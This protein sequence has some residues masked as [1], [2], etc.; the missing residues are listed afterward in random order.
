MRTEYRQ[1]FVL[2]SVAE[3]QCKPHQLNAKEN[4]GFRFEKT[5]WV[6]DTMQWGKA[7]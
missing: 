6:N 7:A 3:G 1:S 5:E 4:N 2:F